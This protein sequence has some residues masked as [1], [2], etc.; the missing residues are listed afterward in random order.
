MILFLGTLSSC[1]FS[2]SKAKSESGS[3]LVKTCIFM[4]YKYKVSSFDLKEQKKALQSEGL[5]RENHKF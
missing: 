3:E 1:A 5:V 2:E 4:N